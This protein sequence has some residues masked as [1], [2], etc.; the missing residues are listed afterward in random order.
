VPIRR[1]APVF[2]VT[3]YAT[4]PLPV[5][6]APEVIVIQLSL[7]FAVHAQVD[8]VVTL[9]LPLSAE[10]ETDLLFGLIE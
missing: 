8:A 9:T 4:V 2:A 7:L 6:E 1:L 3:E 10:D 5:P